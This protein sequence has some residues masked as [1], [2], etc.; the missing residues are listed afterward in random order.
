MDSHEE[1]ASLQNNQSVRYRIGR[2]GRTDVEWEDWK[3]GPLYVEKRESDMPSLKNRARDTWKAGS[4]LMLIPI[5]ENTA[6][7]GQA[8]YCGNGVFCAEDYY[9][10]IADLGKDASSSQDMRK[11][12][13]LAGPSGQASFPAQDG[14]PA[15]ENPQK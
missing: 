12:A 8:D 9:L 14:F 6:E 2:A 5:G 13:E 15:R 3:E 11:N 1:L 4:I 10:E 7:F